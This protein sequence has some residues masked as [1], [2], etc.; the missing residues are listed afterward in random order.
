M[1]VPLL[2]TDIGFNA[3]SLAVGVV[4]L[5]LGVEEAGKTETG[6]IIWFSGRCT[7]PGCGI[8]IL[9]KA[10]LP[11]IAAGIIKFSLSMGGTLP[12]PFPEKEQ[13]VGNC[14]PFG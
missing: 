14:R 2:K 4:C 12:F 1:R 9:G 6:C 7:F 8:W 10:I 11:R 13:P 3:V 5:L